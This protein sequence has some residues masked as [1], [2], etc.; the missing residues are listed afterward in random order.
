[1]NNNSPKEYRVKQ[2]AIIALIFVFIP[3]HVHGD[4]TAEPPQWIKKNRISLGIHTAS[5]GVM[6]LG[7]II[8]NRGGWWDDGTTWL[9]MGIATAGTI[10]VVVPSIP[11]YQQ[12]NIALR[13]SKKGSR[14]R[15][16]ARISKGLEIGAI[17]TAASLYPSLFLLQRYDTA[18][19]LGSLALTSATLFTA[20][21]YV[22][23]IGTHT[24]YHD[25]QTVSPQISVS[26][27]IS[28][29]GTVG[30]HLHG[31]F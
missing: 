15:T 9:G 25:E 5:Y 17:T 16:L 2:L 6:G 8:A 24:L 28:F 23:T 22:Y 3:N 26:P 7:G 20:S 18:P 27:S 10:G 12:R 31:T 13:Y 29:D 21:L 14:K 19:I 11:I 4:E 30:V 1:L